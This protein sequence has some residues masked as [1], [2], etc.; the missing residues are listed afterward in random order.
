M[1]WYKRL[2]S[3]LDM[4]LIKKF[5]GTYF[6]S[7]ALIISIAVVFDFNENIDKFTTN[8]APWKGIISST[9]PT[10]SPIFPTCSVRCSCSSL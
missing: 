7:I 10:S 8:H 4:Y 9:T 3:K 2:I 6:F 1:K 5:L